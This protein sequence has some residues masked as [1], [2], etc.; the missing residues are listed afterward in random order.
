MVQYNKLDKYGNVEALFIV[1]TDL[2]EAFIP[3]TLKDHNHGKPVTEIVGSYT[4]HGALYTPADNFVTDAT[5][6]QPGIF[7]FLE[8]TINGKRVGFVI[9]ADTEEQ[10]QQ[11]RE[12]L[13]TYTPKK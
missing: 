11:L 6:R 5:G 12:T 3:A 10:L 4:A 8:A 2:T 1:Q 7:E 9:A 13:K